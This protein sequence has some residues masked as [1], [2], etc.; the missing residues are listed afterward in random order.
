MRQTE[1]TV[2]KDNLQMVTGDYYRE[3]NARKGAGRNSL[4]HNPEVLFQSLARDAAMVRALGWIG[5]DPHS[6]RVL[7]VGCGDGDSLWILLRLGFEPSNLAGVDIQ[8]DKILQARAKN[9]R[10]NFECASATNL[11]FPDNAF[12]ITMESM[13]FLQLTDDAIARQIASEMIR[14]TKPGGILLVSD[15]RYSRPGSGE[16]K[17]VSPRRIAGL[18]QVGKRTDACRTFRGPLVPPIGRFLSRYFSPAYFVVHA[19][20]PFLAGHMITILRKRKLS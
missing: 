14:V 11:A 2:S 10:V 1:S 13:M 18:Y 19:L 8:E 15:W 16:F 17:G 5:A 6:A 20:F 9:P 7:D 12:D 4:L 3:Y